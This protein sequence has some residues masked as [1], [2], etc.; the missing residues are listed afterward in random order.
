MGHTILVLNA[1]KKKMYG[2]TTNIKSVTVENQ[3]TTTI[4]KKKKKKISPFKEKSNRNGA[5]HYGAGR[6]HK[7]V[8]GST[9][10]IQKPNG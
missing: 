1:S 10:N 5:H 9:T 4:V 6:K 8:Y 3:K 7:K 2:S